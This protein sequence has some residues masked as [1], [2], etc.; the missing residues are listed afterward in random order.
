MLGLK[1][2]SMLSLGLFP[3]TLLQWLALCGM[4]VIART[5]EPNN[6]ILDTSQL[7]YI[8]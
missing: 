5:N 4:E 8:G 7:W 2:K 6:T 1:N 3:V